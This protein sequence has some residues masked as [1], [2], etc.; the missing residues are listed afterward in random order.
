MSVSTALLLTLA[1]L[2]VATSHYQVEADGGAAK[3]IQTTKDTDLPTYIL[4][5]LP[6]ICS[7]K[8]RV[9][10][11]FVN[12]TPNGQ[13][14]MRTF[15][16]TIEDTIHAHITEQAKTDLTDPYLIQIS[17][18]IFHDLIAQIGFS[19]SS[20]LTASCSVKT[21]ETFRDEIKSLNGSQQDALRSYFDNVF[22]VIKSKLPQWYSEAFAKCLAEIS[23]LETSDPFAMVL[24][25][26]YLQD[27]F[28]YSRNI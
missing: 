28:D 17:Q 2:V 12:L 7:F 25:S 18:P 9:A 1:A 15:I 4:V 11:V 14:A 5:R 19:E 24:I 26:P 13:S 21:K 22:R 23:A 3:S 16:K 27:F 10:N 6:D 20:R 8:L